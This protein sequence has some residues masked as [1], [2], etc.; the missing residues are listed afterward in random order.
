[1]VREVRAFLVATTQP[2]H[3]LGRGVRP[4]AP[5]KS[6]SRQLT[7]HL[8]QLGR[9]TLRAATG[10]VPTAQASAP[11]GAGD[12][13][14]T[15]RRDAAS[16]RIRQTLAGRPR[17]RQ[18]HG[19]PRTAAGGC[20]RRTVGCLPATRQ[21]PAGSP[22]D[23]TSRMPFGTSVSSASAVGSTGSKDAPRGSCQPP[24]AFNPLKLNAP[25]IMTSPLRAGKS[26]WSRPRMPNAS[27]ARNGRSDKNQTV[28]EAKPSG[29]GPN[30]RLVVV[31]PAVLHASASG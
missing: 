18:T 30:G 11:N 27:A 29:S 22:L 26:T 20:S 13:T 7:G 15:P 9:T 31:S 2:G 4:A 8:R 21:T 5:G 1:M 6:E 25:P 19:T 24:T 3:R 28:G 10:V 23:G 14:R 16:T 17:T 12:R